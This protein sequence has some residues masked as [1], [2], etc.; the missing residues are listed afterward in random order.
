MNE[1][2]REA[3]KQLAKN[4]GTGAVPFVTAKVKQI[5]WDKRLCK[6]ED[7]DGVEFFDVR[8]RAIADEEKKGFCLKP[9]V[10][11]YVLLGPVNNFSS[12]R[13]VAMYTE[14]DALEIVAD[15]EVLVVDIKEGKF[16]F[17]KGEND[18][19]VKVGPLA[20]KLK[21]VETKV[22]D[23]ILLL[24]SV[25]VALAPSGTFDVGSTFFS[26]VQSLQ[27]TDKSDLENTD[28]TH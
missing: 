23:L 24:K 22:N 15:E 26:S 21:N 28:I 12:S 5:D 27:T 1:E 2:I 6:C 17:N 18:G 25:K 3:I 8:L 14:V 16:T 20:E 11:S 9:K 4:P 19:L 10:D 13:F 7:E